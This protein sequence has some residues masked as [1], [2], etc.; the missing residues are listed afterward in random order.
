M[1]KQKKLLAGTTI[2]FTQNIYVCDDKTS[3]NLYAKA[4][5]EGKIMKDTE[6]HDVYPYLVKKTGGESSFY[7]NS[8]EIEEVKS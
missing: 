2:K 7:C 8:E 1:K 3:G 6:G 4:G 5:D